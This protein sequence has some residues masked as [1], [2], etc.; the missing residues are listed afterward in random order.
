MY[1]C[2]NFPK[3]GVILLPVRWRRAFGF[4]CGEHVDVVKENDDI[5][6]KKADYRTFDHK[7]YISEKGGVN[8]PKEIRSQ[9]DLNQEAEYCL[10]VEPDKKQFVVA[11]E[12]E[13]DERS[14]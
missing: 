9:L 11:L 1:R 7:R 3:S 5:I 6:I 2:R 8:I 14:H 10:Y 4:S 12:T 13:Q